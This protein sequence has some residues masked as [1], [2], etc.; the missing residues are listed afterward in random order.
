[1]TF[2]AAGSLFAADPGI[3][4]FYRGDL[5]KAHTYYDGRLKKEG[6]NEKIMYNLGTTALSM[7]QFDEAAALLNR[8]L[9]DDDP[10]Q[11]AKA[12]YNLG[13]LA[14]EQQKAEEALEHFKKSILLDP[15]DPNS[16]IMF[17]QLLRMMQEQQQE[18]NDD[19]QKDEDQQ[20]GDQQRKDQDRQQDQQQ[21]QQ[22]E[23]DRQKNDQQASSQ[24]SE[25][26]LSP[27]ELTREQA[28]NILNA[29]KEEEKESMKKLIMS[30]ANNKNVKRIR[31][32]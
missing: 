15:D 11:L 16:K 25:E 4:A 24:L 3:K 7:K 27:E 9:A 21:D 26:D 12:H 23:G 13:Q 30:K 17:E 8:S 31:E 32:W 5:E 28:K 20:T 19:Q 18:Q 10:E 22:E 6:E 1:M 29:M 2:A 14:L